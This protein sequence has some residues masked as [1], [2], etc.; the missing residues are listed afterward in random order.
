MKPIFQ[1]RKAYLF[2]CQSD[3]SFYHFI[4]R[5]SFSNGN[6]NKGHSAAKLLISYLDDLATVIETKEN[7]V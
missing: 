6:L 4:S 3:L 7:A 2:R 1:S 5:T